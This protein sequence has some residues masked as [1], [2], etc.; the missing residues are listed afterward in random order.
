MPD[1]TP[2]Q[3]AAAEF[4]IHRSSLHRYLADGRLTA[5]K[6]VGTKKTFIDREQLRELLTPK[7]VKRRQPASRRK[8]QA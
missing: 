3:D 2:L 5:Y 1:L 7:P 4:G 6:A 8:R